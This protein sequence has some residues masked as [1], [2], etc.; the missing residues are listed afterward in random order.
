MGSLLVQDINIS[1]IAEKQTDLVEPEAKDLIEE[2][3]SDITRAVEEPKSAAED[4]EKEKSSAPTSPTSKSATSS[5]PPL[6]TKQPAKAAVAASRSQVK[7]SKPEKPASPTPTKSSLARA[8]VSKRPT[9]QV[10]GRAKTVDLG[11]ANAPATVA[12]RKSSSVDHQPAKVVRQSSLG[13]MQSQPSPTRG[14]PGRLSLRLKGS[15]SPVK[16]LTGAACSVKSEDL[17]KTSSGNTW[18]IG[19]SLSKSFK[20]HL[21]RRRTKAVAWVEPRWTAERPWK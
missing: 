4:D 15:E 19:K 20:S 12:T 6:A 11:K 16:R 5:P 17:K 14:A 13:T 3:K 18:D 2:S 7:V 9:Q 1:S 21:N 10:V 8:G